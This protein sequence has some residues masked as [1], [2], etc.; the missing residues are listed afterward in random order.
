MLQCLLNGRLQKPYQPP[1][2]HAY[3]ALL[4]GDGEFMSTI[5]ARR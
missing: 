2:Q 4:R 3:P 1:I 5:A